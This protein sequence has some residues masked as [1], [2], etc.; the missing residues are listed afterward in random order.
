MKILSIVRLILGL[1]IALLSPIC[2]VYMIAAMIWG[3]HVIDGL[4]RT[5]PSFW[6]I[7]ILICPLMS[8]SAK[9]YLSN[10]LIPGFA[11]LNILNVGDTQDLELWIKWVEHSHSK[12]SNKKQHLSDYLKN[13]KAN[14][15]R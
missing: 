12:I 1:F 14:K 3:S 13:L 9:H 8:V 10:Y 2:V 15:N 7:I 5:H 6:F 11:K 4:G